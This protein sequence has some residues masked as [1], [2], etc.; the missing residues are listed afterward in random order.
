MTFP[1]WYEKDGTK[2]LFSEEPKE[3]GW[4]PCNGHY[5]FALGVWVD[6]KPA[7][8]PAKAPRA[9]EGKEELKGL[10]ALYKEAT[11]KRPFN[12]WSADELREKLDAL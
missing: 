1:K 8:K 6:D 12:G 4:E 2:K 5:D 7:K 10:R 11:G 9:A 3:V